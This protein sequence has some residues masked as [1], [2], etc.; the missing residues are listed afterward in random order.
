M[1]K[2]APV[3]GDRR[4]HILEAALDVFAEYG[5]EKAT[6]KEIA[7]RVGVAQ[8]LVYFYF[9]HKRDLLFAACKH[10]TTLA[11]AQ[12]GANEKDNVPGSPQA[13][14]RK[15]ITRFMQVLD[16]PRNAKLLRVIALVEL[17]EDH[18]AI[19]RATGEAQRGQENNSFEHKKQLGM[20]VTRLNAEL[21]AH[22]Q[23]CL[24]EYPRPDEILFEA[25]FLSS[26]ITSMLIKRAVNSPDQTIST[27]FAQK[28]MIEGVLSNVFAWLAVKQALIAGEMPC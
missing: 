16:E 8:G 28:Q 2:P 21:L 9:D 25:E 10:Q 4:Q 18:P 17:P 22:L 11:L 27:Q 5:F 7:T 12:L 15:V 23:Q 6:T 20:L 24:P 19:E 1:R 13:E 3:D 14:L 26:A